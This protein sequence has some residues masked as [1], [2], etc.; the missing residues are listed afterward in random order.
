MAIPQEWFLYF[1][2]FPMLVG[3]LA[4]FALAVFEVQLIIL[5]QKKKMLPADLYAEL[6]QKPARLRNVAGITA[7]CCFFGGPI[8]VGGVYIFLMFRS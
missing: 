4:A 6:I 2:A 7:V 3:I 8:L 1:G 5:R